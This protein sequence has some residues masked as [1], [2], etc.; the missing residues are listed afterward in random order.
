MRE[1]KSPTDPHVGDELINLGM[2]V[3]EQGK[4]D[5]ARADYDRALEI[6]RKVYGA[7][8]PMV[9]TALRQRA[10]L[11]MKTPAA[12]TDL[13]EALRITIAA[14]GPDK[15]EVGIIRGNLA[16][17]YDGVKNL[18]EAVSQY[19]QAIAIQDKTLGVVTCSPAWR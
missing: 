19:E 14:V 8:H 18:H 12:V 6:Y 7:N 5:E 13:E 15:P 11:E 2:D 4:V 17:A 10:Q 1:A 3:V 9:A 16:S